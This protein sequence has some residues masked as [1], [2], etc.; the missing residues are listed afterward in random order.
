MTGRVPPRGGREWAGWFG[1][2]PWRILAVGM[3]LALGVAT[4]LFSAL[5]APGPADL[6]QLVATLAVAAV[7]AVAL[8]YLFY[9]RGW[10]RSSSLMVTMVM[11]YLWAA[12]VTLLPVW[13]LQRQMFFSEHDLAL[14]GVLLL[15]AAIVATTYGLFI[16]TSVAD[17]LRQ[18]AAAAN[19]LAAGDPAARAPITGRDE[20]AR[21][22]ASFNAMADQLQ[23]AAHRR[24][25]VETLRRNLIAWT[26]HDLR[27]PLTAIRVRVEALHDGI[28]TEPEEVRRY[29]AAMR[30]D[31]VALDSLLDDLFE[32]AQLDA[33]GPPAARTL[34]A[35][36]DFVADAL[37]RFRPLAE[38]RD[39]D[40]IGE[41]TTTAAVAVEPGKIERVLGNLIGNALRHTPPGGQVTLAAGETPEGVVFRVEDTGPGFSAADLAYGFEQFYRG[42]EARTRATGG[43]GLGLAIARGIVQAHGGHIWAENRAEGGARVGFLL[44][45]AGKVAAGSGVPLTG[46]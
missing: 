39:I 25:E 22:G 31:V 1:R 27:T 38:R 26:S 42:E 4:A 6:A 19:R 32:L 2:A 13:L 12:L 36:A 33:G 46:N 9:R 37:E 24:E 43:A 44:P 15:F 7:L 10:A 16:A 35:P 11:T 21:L 45:R 30:A 14:S 17:G 28:V 20:V 18:M 34:H 8:G 23:A 5:M 29:V 3:L 41:A 40:L